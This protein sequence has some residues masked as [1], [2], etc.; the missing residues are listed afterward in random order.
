MTS[1]W[2]VYMT[3]D[4]RISMA[5]LSGSKCRWATKPWLLVLPA[6][7]LL[8]ELGQPNPGC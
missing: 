8:P 6:P 2:H 1:K 5:G 7:H 3:K 4:G